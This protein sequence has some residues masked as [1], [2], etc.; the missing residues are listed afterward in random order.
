MWHCI[1]L[2]RDFVETLTKFG[3]LPFASIQDSLD[4]IANLKK[5]NEL[6]RQ[7]VSPENLKVVNEE[8]DKVNKQKQTDD[9]S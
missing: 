7:H 6:L 9:E 5:E 1:Y 4:E 3:C 2:K 8:M